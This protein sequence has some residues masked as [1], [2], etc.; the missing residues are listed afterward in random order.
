MLGWIVRGLMIA[1]GVITGFFVAKDAPLYGVVQTMM[2]LGLMTAIV[3]AAAFWPDK[4]M[5][6]FNRRHKR[7]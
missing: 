4:W 5:P 3:A 1:A 7:R 2:A 6:G